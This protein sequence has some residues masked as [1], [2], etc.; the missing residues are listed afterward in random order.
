MEAPTP[1]C[2]SARGAASQAELAQ[3]VANSN[4]HWQRCEH[5]CHR[6]VGLRPAEPPWALTGT[7]ICVLQWSCKNMDRAVQGY[8][9]GQKQT[10]VDIVK[11]RTL[12]P[13]LGFLESDVTTTTWQMYTWFVL[14][15][16]SQP[17]RI[18]IEWSKIKV[19]VIT[20][21]ASRYDAHKIF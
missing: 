7:N 3:H 9:S 10:F 20:M 6:K 21:G 4:C 2:M 14:S 5:Q 11:L 15:P 1:F 8:T 12:P 17:N 18:D 19:K 13:L 16:K